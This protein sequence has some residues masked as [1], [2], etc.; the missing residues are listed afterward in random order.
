MDKIIS[1][2]PKMGEVTAFFAN[3]F[4]T[5]PNYEN[6]SQIPSLTPKTDFKTKEFKVIIDGDIRKQSSV[7]TFKWLSRPKIVQAIQQK[8]T[9]TVTSHPQ[10]KLPDFVKKLPDLKY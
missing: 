1:Y 6:I 4:T 2:I 5:N 3:Q 9:Q 10:A 7:K 8:T